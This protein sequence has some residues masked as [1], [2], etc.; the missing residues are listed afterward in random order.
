MAELDL[1][2]VPGVIEVTNNGKKA[3]NVGISGINQQFPLAPG[4]TVKLK[5]ESTSELLGYLSQETD[6]LVVT[7]PSE[8]DSEEDSSDGDTSQEE[9][10]SGSGSTDVPSD[11]VAQVDGT[12]YDTLQEALDAASSGATIELYS[13]VE[14][15]EPLVISK[16]IT[17]GG[18][19]TISSSSVQ[20]PIEISGNGIDVTIEG[21]ILTSTY[22]T[23]DTA[24]Y[25]TGRAITVDLSSGSVELSLK[26]VTLTATGGSTGGYG[27]AIMVESA[28]G[29]TNRATI[30]IDSCTLSAPDG[31]ALR[32]YAPADITVTNS[33]LSGWS[34][35]YFQAHGGSS[36]GST[37]SIT[38]CTMT[39]TGLNGSTN[40]FGAFVI[41][42]AIE[43]ITIVGGSLEVI[44]GTATQALLSLDYNPGGTLT[45]NNITI[46]GSGDNFVARGVCSYCI[47][48]ETAVD[49]Q[50]QSGVTLNF[51]VPDDFIAD[52]C[53]LTSSSDGI[54]TVVDA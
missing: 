24:I 48:D 41:C 34:I 18:E 38:D 31:H 15:D 43:N 39:S 22:A 5:V 25:D 50:L 23:N 47:S 4:V 46:V 45:M 27:S 28:S 13:D 32:I 12:N 16:S 19:Y 9:G 49:V 7:L 42:T 33:T 11:T 29:T 26:D 3:V 2:Q 37:L 30:D 10:N 14:V 35:A 53:T 44:S 20:S 36:A 21:V 54:Y 52:G 8:S 6:A 40:D 1:S 17:L 51:S